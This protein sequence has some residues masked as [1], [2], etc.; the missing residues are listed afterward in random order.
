MRIASRFAVAVHMLILM[1]ECA[2]RGTSCTSE[3]MAGSVNTN[4]V[5]I[6]KLS[7]LLKRATLIEVRAGTGGA[8]VTKPLAVVR[9]LD[10]YRAVEAVEPPGLFSLHDQ[11]N[12]ACPVGAN[13]NGALGEVL[14][15][16]QTAMEAVLEKRTV[17]DVLAGVI[18]RSRIGK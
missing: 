1:D 14:G 15:E 3:L 8:F 13:I 11:P 6:R 17:A 9:L 7:G 10:V 4:P 5:V 12:P 18:A 2:K 16:A